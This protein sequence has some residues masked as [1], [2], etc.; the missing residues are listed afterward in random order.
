MG[1][2]PLIDKEVLLERF[3]GKGGWTYISLP[4]VPK[5][6]RNHFGWR[7]VYGSIDSYELA[8]CSLMPFKKGVLML[9][10]KAAIRKQIGKQAG[11]RVRLVLYPAGQATADVLPDDFMECL[12]DEPAALRAFEA[13]P[14]AEQEKCMQWLMEINVTDARIQRM[15]DAINHLAAGRSWLGARKQ[16]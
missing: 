11:D 9:P 16:D 12:R 10:V 3:E 14:K 8:P 6:M 4:E 5:D 13:M 7:K 2:A 1:T 15:A